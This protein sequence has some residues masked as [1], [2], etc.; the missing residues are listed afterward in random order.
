VLRN[1]EGRSVGRRQF[2]PQ[3]KKVEHFG[4][5]LYLEGCIMKK[6]PITLGGNAFGL[7]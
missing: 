3:L 7:K 1:D 5:I 6:L 4:R 2:I